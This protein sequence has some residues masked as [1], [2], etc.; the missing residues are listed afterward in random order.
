MNLTFNKFCNRRNVFICVCFCMY[1]FLCISLVLYW[2]YLE[3]LN[4]EPGAS[5]SRKHQPHQDR[6]SVIAGDISQSNGVKSKYLIEVWGK[7]SISLYL[8]NHILKGSLEELYNGFMKTGNLTVDNLVFS[9]KTGPGFIQT[10]VPASVKYLVLVLNGRSSD[11]IEK[12]KQWLDY[13]PKFTLLKK[14]AVVL[15]GSEQC[16]NNWILPYMS[17][18]GGKVNVVFLVYDSTVVDNNEFYQWP[19][20]VAEYRGFPNIRG[21]SVDWL[22]KRQYKCNFLGTVYKNSSREILVDELKSL[23]SSYK[24]LLYERN[25]W[26]P[27]ETDISL[28]KYIDALRNSDLTL[29]PAGMNTECYRIYEA[30]SLGSVPVVENNLTPGV[31]DSKHPS[32]LRLLKRYKAPVIWIKDWHDLGKILELESKLTHREIVKR[33]INIVR[34]Y[35][36]FKNS[37][38]NL[39][40]QVIKHKFYE[41]NVT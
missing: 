17:S 34:W 7:A 33:R 28:N 29:S 22:T 12:A 1:I 16:D 30:M 40:I 6:M 2:L 41:T 35:K 14:V 27:K 23:K 32:P 38:K 15:L 20:G 21:A 4:S 39:F 37:M 24:I 8:W 25:E 10:T 13:L 26:M 31:C 11:K 5:L 9:F 3:K 36:N 19:L 18:R